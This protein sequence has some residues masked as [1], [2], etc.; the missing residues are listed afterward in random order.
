MSAHAVKN[1]RLHLWLRSK[2]Y[3]KQIT[4]RA[5]CLRGEWSWKERNRFSCVNLPRHR[6]SCRPSAGSL[7]RNWNFKKY[8]NTADLPTGKQE[9]RKGYTLTLVTPAID[10][11]LMYSSCTSLTPA[12]KQS[13]GVCSGDKCKMRVSKFRPLY[14]K[15]FE[16]RC[17][18]RSQCVRYWAVRKVLEF[19]SSRGLSYGSPAGTF[20]YK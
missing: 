18:A 4:K 1:L 8:N 5:F 2:K 17:Q 3:R 14:R 15:V 12:D 16:S 11:L 13:C 7:Q 10:V 6:Y 19:R 20:A 9:S